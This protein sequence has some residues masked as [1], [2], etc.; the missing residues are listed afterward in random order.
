MGSPH[1][2]NGKKQ[3]VMVPLPVEQHAELK[4]LARSQHRSMA[5]QAAMAIEQHLVREREAEATGAKL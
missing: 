4:A 1:T 5:A 2:P 3:V